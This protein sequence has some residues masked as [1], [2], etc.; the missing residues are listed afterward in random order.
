MTKHADELTR[1]FP[2][3]SDFTAAALAG[4]P[5]RKRRCKSP[6]SLAKVL[7]DDLFKPDELCDMAEVKNPQTHFER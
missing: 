3:T 5:E 6:L 4:E 7:L 1:R 2:R